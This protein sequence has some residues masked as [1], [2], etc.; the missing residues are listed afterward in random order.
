MS[1]ARLFGHTAWFP[2]AQG[3]NSQAP[4]VGGGPE[5]VCGQEPVPLTLEGYRELA[6]EHSQPGPPS[7]QVLSQEQQLQLVFLEV[8]VLTE[9]FRQSGITVMPGR[10]VRVA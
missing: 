2:G 9:L 1:Y 6:T 3:Q 4:R 8:S 10:P 7:P 5:G